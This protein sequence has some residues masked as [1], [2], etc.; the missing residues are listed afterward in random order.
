MAARSTNSCHRV[1]LALA[2]GAV[3]RHA[4]HREQPLER[5]READPA[6]GH[7]GRVRAGG[8]Q[9]FDEG[10]HSG[11]DV[12]AVVQHHQRLGPGEL[13]EHGVGRGPAH[14]FPETERAGHRRS[15]HGRVGHRHQVDIPRPVGEATGHLGGNGQR[16]AGLAHP[17]RTDRGDQAMSRQ[18]VG[19]RG[20]F[21]R[22]AHEGGQRRRKRR[23]P[24]SPTGVALGGPIAL[25]PGLDRGDEAIAATMH[26]TDH[27]LTVAVVADGAARRLDPTGERRLADEAVTP[28][29]VEQLL[30]GH[31]PVPVG[32]QVGEHIEH[33]R[34]DLHDR[35]RVAQFE[36]VA[37]EFAVT[38]HEDHR[39][40]TPR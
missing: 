29:L 12:L 32:D 23:C 22:P 26:G 11:H 40:L 16:Q 33:L 20:P 34:F 30:L 13:G 1:A 36:R 38:E 37:V 10:D 3:E 39:D 25:D 28:H 17:A 27:H 8:Q 14:L 31:H 24:E 6:G 2:V 19:Q 5:H 18:S 21:R 4:R 15:D 35:T 7:D 9:P